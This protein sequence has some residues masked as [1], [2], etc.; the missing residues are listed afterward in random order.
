M[1]LQEHL[2]KGLLWTA[3]QQWGVQAIRMA[4]L[5]VL[6]RLVAP[7]SFGVFALASTIVN[8]IGLIYG[9]GMTAALTQR[10]RLEKRHIGSA[11]VA[12]LVSG[13]LASAAVVLIAPHI[14]RSSMPQLSSLLLILS[15]QFPL[16]AVS[17][18]AMA[19]WRRDLRFRRMAVVTTVSQLVASVISIAI[20]LY[21][22]GVWSLA[23]RVLVEAVVMLLFTLHAAPWS[24]LREAS[25]SAYRE[26]IRFGM[27]VAG[28]NL[29]SLGRARL[30]ELVIG[31]I[32]GM[33][34][35]G[36]YSLARRQT[37]GIASLL[38]SVIGNAF[39]PVLARVQGSKDA[40]RALV[41]RG[42]ALIGTLTLPTLGAI[43]AAASLWVPLLLGER[44]RPA[45][46]LLAGFAVIAATRALV[47]FNLT[48]LPATG[49][50]GKRLIA[51][52]AA[53]AASLLTL[54][55][56]VGYGIRTVVVASACCMVLLTPMELLWASRWLPV[57]VGDQLKMLR[58]P[59]LAAV[60]VIGIALVLQWTLLGRAHPAICMVILALLT[61]VSMLVVYRSIPSMDVT[62]FATDPAL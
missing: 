9:Q 23:A 29:L 46:P 4:V 18:T 49:H 61:G 11:L 41:L 31:A 45:A 3:T 32:L 35:L 38:P 44:W 6:A 43:G 21:G 2:R 55:A 28:G 59:A 52:L 22:F 47:G 17:G 57:K 37:D 56:T 36:Y 33:E 62:T 50:P 5:L 30:D 42:V 53:T 24:S 58:Y 27:P 34:A 7:A 16:N 15:L 14:T 51:E 48:T 39:V 54:Y 13:T 8:V 12:L 19:L 25:W 40:V 1:S 20:A 10:A 26:M 60:F